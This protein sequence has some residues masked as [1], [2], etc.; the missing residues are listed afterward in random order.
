MHMQHEHAIFISKTPVLI[1]GDTS[2]NHFMSIHSSAQAQAC[3]LLVTLPPQEDS[4]V[5][6][7]MSWWSSHPQDTTWT[8]TMAHFGDVVEFHGIRLRPQHCAAWQCF[9]RLRL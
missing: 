5:A 3:A 1:S 2:A 6:T 4:P 8:D 7:N 9:R